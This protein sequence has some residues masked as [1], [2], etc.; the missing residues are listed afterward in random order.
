MTDEYTVAVEAVASS[1]LWLLITGFKLG[2]NLFVGYFE[3]I[4]VTDEYTVAVE[5]V[6]FICT[7]LLVL[8]FKLALNLF[9]GYFDP[10]VADEVVASIGIGFKLVLN[11]VRYFEAISVTDEYSVAVE[12]VSFICMSLLILG[13]K[14]AL[15]FFVLS[16]V[17][18]DP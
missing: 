18:E 3:A 7:C 13:F 5:A 12:P 2:L 15:H 4:S 6:S 14:L 9:V 8:D 1:C 11:F 17:A 10:T 16:F